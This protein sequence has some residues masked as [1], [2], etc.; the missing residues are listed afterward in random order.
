[1]PRKADEWSSISGDI[2]SSISV[3]IKKWIAFSGGPR[4]SGETLCAQVILISSQW[5]D[6]LLL[7]SVEIDV[8]LLHILAISQQHITEYKIHFSCFTK[9]ILPFYIKDS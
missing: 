9:L 5:A 4:T 3:F 8:R 2:H 7:T 1:M 6:Q